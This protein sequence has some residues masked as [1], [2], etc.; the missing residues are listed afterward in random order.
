MIIV[1]EQ[2]I[3]LFLFAVAGYSLCK[4]NIV[5]AEHSQILSKLLVYVFLPCNII[6]TFSSNFE[7]QYVIAN[8]RIIVFSIIILLCLSITMHFVAKLFQKMFMIEK[9]MNIHCSYLITGIWDMHWQ[10]HFLVLRA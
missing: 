6:K 1:F 4:L 2:V 7:Q 9:S 3:I 10:K 8:Y 5:R